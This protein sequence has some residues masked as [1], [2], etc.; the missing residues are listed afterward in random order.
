M[1]VYSG[2]WVMVQLPLNQ[3]GRRLE[4]WVGILWFCSQNRQLFFCGHHSNPMYGIHVPPP[5]SILNIFRAS[6]HKIWVPYLREPASYTVLH[7]R[8]PF[9]Q[10]IIY[11]RNSFII[12]QMLWQFSTIGSWY[13]HRSINSMAAARYQGDKLRT[14]FFQCCSRISD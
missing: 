4:L 2:L 14:T 12:T 11:F 8:H 9:F 1:E 6:T 10:M 5:I 7:T 13:L 3:V